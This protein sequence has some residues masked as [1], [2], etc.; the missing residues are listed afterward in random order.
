MKRQKSNPTRYECLYENCGK[1]YLRASQLA[2]HENTHTGNV[3]PII[4][5]VDSSVHLNVKNAG[6]RTGKAVISQDINKPIQKR[7]SS[8]L[9]QIVTIPLLLVNISKDMKTSISNLIPTRF[10]LSPDKFNS[11]VLTSL[12][13]PNH[14]GK[15]ISFER[16]SQ[17]S[18]HRL[19]HFHVPT[20]T[21]VVKL[22]LQFNLNLLFT[23]QNVIQNDIFVTIV[24][25]RLF[26][27]SIFNDIVVMTIV[28][29]VLLVILNLPLEML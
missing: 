9:F 7:D 10:S 16:I 29:D 17:K 2:E 20:P 22:L 11:S 1:S 28:H 8:V 14:S 25:N 6:G 5:R 24:M 3:D 18:I 23:S 19:H 21:R 26:F 12:P 27:F 13:V 15:N 4:F